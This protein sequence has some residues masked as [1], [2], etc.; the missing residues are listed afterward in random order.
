MLPGIVTKETVNLYTF[1]H[2][3]KN[4]LCSICISGNK[5]YYVTKLLND[6]EKNEK[7]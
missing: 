7:I 6:F 4:E 3:K 1:K 5:Y 2:I